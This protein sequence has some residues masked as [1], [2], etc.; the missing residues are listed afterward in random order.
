[1]FSS[2]TRRTNVNTVKSFD[3][4]HG[5]IVWVEETIG[6]QE[7]SLTFDAPTGGGVFV[8]MARWTSERARKRGK[9][10][11]S[12]GVALT[13]EAAEEIYRLLGDLLNEPDNFQG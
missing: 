1:M 7:T 13:Y 10:Q 2:P 6:Q 9:A 3:H 4:P 5:R 8:R 12:M 11:T